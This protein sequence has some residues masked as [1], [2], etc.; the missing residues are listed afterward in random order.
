VGGVGSWAAEALARS[1][2]G[3]L[4]LVDMDHVAESNIN[5]QLVALDS[6]LGRSKVGVL[7]E[8]IA[9]VNPACG[10]TL[11]EE[12][13][14]PH[15]VAE[16]IGAGFD[17]VIDCIDDA[18]AK[19]A[20]IAYCRRRKIPLVTVGGAGGQVDPT[21]IRVSDLSRSAQDRLLARVR[22]LLRQDYGFSR[23]PQRRFDVP[24]V[25]SDEQMVFPGR[26]GGV[27]LQPSNTEG[28]GNLSCAGGI[29]SVVTV[30]ASFGM[31]AAAHAMRRLVRLSGD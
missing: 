26:D 23:N 12:F 6:T 7:A 10:T 14:G 21:R 15:N 24:C 17:Q 27:C 5:R 9:D 13:I 30:T 8:R 29:G 4:T 16:V 18:R 28:R 25:W 11:V 22:K 20:L 3:A 2:V 19:A 1:G 31:V